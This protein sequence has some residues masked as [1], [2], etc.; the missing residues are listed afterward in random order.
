MKSQQGS[1]PPLFLAL[2]LHLSRQAWIAVPLLLTFRLL[3]FY[4]ESSAP[5]GSGKERIWATL[6]WW[7]GVGASL[8]GHSLESGKCIVQ[9]CGLNTTSVQ[10]ATRKSL[11]SRSKKE[12]GELQH[13]KASFSFYL[14]QPTALPLYKEANFLSSRGSSC[15]PAGADKSGCV[16]LLSAKGLLVEGS[17][18]LARVS[19]GLAPSLW[20]PAPNSR[21]DLFSRL[22][23]QV[24]RCLVDRGVSIR[25]VMLPSALPRA[26]RCRGCTVRCSVLCWLGLGCVTASPAI[27]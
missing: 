15:L 3:A 16:A 2:Y 22:C 9:L 12:K 25:A 7:I 21:H 5:A 26:P 10:V 6:L 13:W 4:P 18:K 24:S 1:S 11:K 23:H 17:T 8:N 27:C 19:Q 20:N 14:P